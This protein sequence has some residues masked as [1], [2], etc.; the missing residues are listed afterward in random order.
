MGLRLKGKPGRAYFKPF[1]N[2]RQFNF[3]K[4]KLPFLFQFF[5]TFGKKPVNFFVLDGTTGHH[6]LEVPTYFRMFSGAQ[7]SQKQTNYFDVNIS[8][9]YSFLM[10]FRQKKYCDALFGILFLMIYFRCF[11]LAKKIN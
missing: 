10:S 8:L 3:G 4:I 7:K 1:G 9:Q 11:V 2:C 5:P 6:C